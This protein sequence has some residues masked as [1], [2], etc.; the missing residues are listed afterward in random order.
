MRGTGGLVV[1][2]VLGA[3]LAVSSPADAGVRE[4]DINHNGNGTYNHNAFSIRS[5]TRNSG[6]QAISNANA[7]GVSSS[8]NAVCKHSRVCHIHQVS[9]D[10]PW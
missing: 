6:F 1:L 9:G 10:F 8:R 7:G 2:L 3:G 5:P 4:G